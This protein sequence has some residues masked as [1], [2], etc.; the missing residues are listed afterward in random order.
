MIRRPPRSTLFPYTTLFRS[1]RRLWFSA[2]KTSRFCRASALHLG[3][4]W[5]RQGKLLGNRHGKRKASAMPRRRRRRQLPAMRL[6]DRSADRQ[7]DTDPIR[8]CCVETLENAIEIL[9][10]ETAAGI[11]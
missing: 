1:P 5:L 7:P 8:L 2:G 11:F 3:A 9:Q 10:I 6:D 4:Y